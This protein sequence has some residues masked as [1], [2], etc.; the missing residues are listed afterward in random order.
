VGLENP[1]KPLGFCV[2]HCNIVP[3]GGKVLRDHDNLVYVTAATVYLR[4]RSPQC[5]NRKLDS[6]DGRERPKGAES[7]TPLTRGEGPRLSTD[8]LNRGAWP[9]RGLPFV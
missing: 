8:L 7:G 6:G 2:S 3:S 4:E 5:F 1:I 9:S